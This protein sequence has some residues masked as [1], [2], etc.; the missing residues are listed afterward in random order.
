MEKSPKIVLAIGKLTGGGAERVVSLWANALCKHGFDVSIL[1]ESRSEK[2]Y[3][4]SDRV[5]I[6]AVSP[7]ESSFLQ[8]GYGK[9]L[10]RMRSIIKSIGPDFVISFLPTMQIYMMFATWGLG[11]RRIETIRINPWMI[12]LSL[13]RQRLWRWT[14]RSAWRIIL[15][16]E[17]QA[18]FFSEMEQRKAVV[19]PNPLSHTYEKVAPRPMHSEVLS[20]LAV[21]RIDAQKNY[22]LMIRGFAEVAREYPQLTLRIYGEGNPSYVAEVQRVIVEQGMENQ[23]VLMGRSTEIEAVYQTSDLFLMTSDFEG[24]PNA[25]IEAMASR[26]ICISTDCKTGPKDL[27]TSGEQGWLVP[28]GERKALAEAIRRV[29]K[30]DL[31]ARERMADAARERVMMVC[32]EAQSIG[33][34]CE[35]LS[36]ERPISHDS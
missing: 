11:I 27:I 14:Y 8:M 24:S 29:L 15:Q 19:I 9:R 10:W 7:T 16:T 22:P 3:A 33:R 28:V 4:V 34:L 6:C 31:T 18:S 1:L 23:V 5:R 26:L 32:S 30:M 21:G 2:E 36:S 17:E 13:L 35:L 12:R 20:C 25:L